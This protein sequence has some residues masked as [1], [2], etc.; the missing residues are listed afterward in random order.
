M[1]VCFIVSKG[2]DEG[3]EPP[4]PLPA[5]EPRVPSEEERAES[6]DMKV[7]GLN[8]AEVGMYDSVFSKKAKKTDL[9]SNFLKSAKC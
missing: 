1:C 9:I 5:S 6:V 3:E 7:Q 8:I 2:L 4:P